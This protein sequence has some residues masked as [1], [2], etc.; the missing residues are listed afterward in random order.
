MNKSSNETSENKVP[1]LIN[2]M[3]PK[4]FYPI[5]LFILLLMIVLIIMFSGTNLNN[6]TDDN[7]K[8][9]IQITQNVFIILFFLIILFIICLAAIPNFKEM[10]DLLYNINSVSSVIVYTIA[11]ILYF[12]YMPKSIIEKY[13]YFFLLLTI[14]LGVFSF[15]KA[16]TTNYAKE[17]NINYE[18]IKSIILLFCFITITIIFSVN[19]P[20]GTISKY[21][22]SLYILTILMSAFA[23]AYLIIIMSLSNETVLKHQSTNLLESF[24]KFGNYGTFLFFAFLVIVTILITTYPGGFFTDK[25]KPRAGIIIV[26]IIW[27]CSIWGILLVSNLFPE[28]TN[29]DLYVSKLETFKKSLLLLFGMCL[30]I[31]S[32]M[33]V[34]KASKDSTSDTVSLVVNIVLLLSIIGLIYSIV[35]KSP[36]KNEKKSGVSKFIKSIFSYIPCGLSELM[37]NMSTGD[38]SM[39]YITIFIGV[40]VLF[41][42]YIVT[43]IIYNKFL[44]QG[45]TVLLSD[46]TPTTNIQSL[47]NYQSLN[48]SGNIEYNYAISFWFFLNSFAPNSNSSYNTYSTIMS[49]ADKPTISYNASLN[50]LR[51]T[52]K[53]LDLKNKTKNKL[54]DFTEKGERIIYTK[55]DMPLQKWNNIILN[56]DGGTLDIFLNGELVSSNI[57]VTPY[58]TLDNLTVGQEN[59]Y[60][61][62]VCNL[63]YFEK[64]LT[65]NNIY[66]VYDKFKN[67]NP[68]I[69]KKNYF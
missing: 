20:N 5:W 35:V 26:L 15:Y 17:F 40:I 27:I 30:T 43:P 69:I 2:L 34:I 51:V 50:T 32:I 47:G 8:Q 3:S 21:F 1:P 53:Q 16:F 67:E 33:W 38:D 57:E 11:L 7:T 23:L 4:I 13:P 52:L 37:E 9:A 44:L 66:Y 18:R 59:G 48:N 22:G 68:P 31:I 28:I 14:G 56:F 29:N 49:Y 63:I 36:V 42:G 41:T 65:K 55:K 45:G 62:S 39:Q 6:L 61:A 12:S 25:N 64:T 46:P 58:Y 10:K 54:I 19:D 24:T 60:L